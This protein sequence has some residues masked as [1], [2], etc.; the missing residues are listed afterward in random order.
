LKSAD[1][2]DSPA[3]SLEVPFVTHLSKKRESYVSN[4][5]DT[6]HERIG[7][8]EWARAEDLP[9]LLVGPR[10]ISPNKVMS[11]VFQSAPDI[12]VERSRP[13]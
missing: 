3:R 4:G 9:I 2:L 11:A 5:S 10:C 1:S 8:F 12:S 13:L 6:R 7:W